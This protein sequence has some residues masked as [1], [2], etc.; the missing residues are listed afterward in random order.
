MIQRLGDIDFERIEVVAVGFP[1]SEVARVERWV[2]GIKENVLDAQRLY[3]TAISTTPVDSWQ[4]RMAREMLESAERSFK[5]ALG[6]LRFFKSVRIRLDGP[7]ED[8]DFC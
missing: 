5:T 7:A 4:R 3:A 8:D 6:H 2:L 1:R